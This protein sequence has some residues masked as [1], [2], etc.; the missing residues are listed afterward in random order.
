MFTLIPAGVITYLPVQLIHQ[1]S[2]LQLLLLVSSASGFFALAF[3]VF[4]LGLR[5]YESG[6][7]F[8]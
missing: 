7:T 8:N 2:W 1:F 5:R 3:G 6:N 4:Y